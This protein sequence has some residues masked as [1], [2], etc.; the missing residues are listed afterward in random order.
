MPGRKLLYM[1]RRPLTAGQAD[2]VFLDG[3]SFVQ[4]ENDISVVLLDSAVMDER[5][6]PGRIFFLQEGAGPRL[7]RPDAKGISYAELVK[8]I[9][10]SDST[11]VI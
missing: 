4:E 2:D 8:L 3:R 9:F 6:F 7:I 5:Q 11:V 10:E 1:L